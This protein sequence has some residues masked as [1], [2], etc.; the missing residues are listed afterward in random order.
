MRKSGLTTKDLNEPITAESLGL[1]PVCGENPRPHHKVGTCEVECLS[2]AMYPDKRLRAWKCRL[3]FRLV[4]DGGEVCAFFHLGRGDRPHAGPNSEYRRAWCI[5]AG[6]PPRK[7]Q[8]L[9][10][11]IFKGKL[12]QVELGNVTKRADQTIHAKAAEYSVVR[13]ILSRTFP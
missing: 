13:R 6:K 5:A 1:E 11:R 12:F 10:S 8:V 2:A 3:K 4:P 9:S 7:R